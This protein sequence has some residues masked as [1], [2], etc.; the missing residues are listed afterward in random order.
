[1]SV[2]LACGHPRRTRSA[3]LGAALKAALVLDSTDRAEEIAVLVPAYHQVGRF[4]GV[5][6]VAEG[7]ASCTRVE[8]GRRTGDPAAHL[9][10][11]APRKM[12]HN[13]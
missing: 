9:V 7:G 8:W 4:N 3:V 13:I 10:R 2:H 12:G 1:M 11:L 6:L 5:V